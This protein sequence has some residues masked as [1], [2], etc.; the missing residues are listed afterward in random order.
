MY[1]DDQI[2]P[3]GLQ[4]L[5]EC[6]NGKYKLLI[7]DSPDIALRGLDYRS[8]D[9]GMLFISTRSFQHRREMIQAAYRVGRGGD[10]CRRVLMGDIELVD[11]MASCAYKNK[12]IRFLDTLKP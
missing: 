2:S 1:I 11:R 10:R 7:A 4:N 5:D 8:Y 9:N 6:R 12:L 3:T